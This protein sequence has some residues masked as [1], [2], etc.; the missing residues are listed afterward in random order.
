MP[1]QL[2]GAVGRLQ[3][4]L[5]ARAAR[6]PVGQL[7]EQPAR[8][9]GDVGDGRVEIV[10]H[11]R[12][13]LTDFSAGRGARGRRCA[14]APRRGLELAGLLE[15]LLQPRQRAGVS[16]RV[17]QFVLRVGDVVN[18]LM[19]PGGVLIPTEGGRQSIQAGFGQLEAQVIKVGMAAEQPVPPSR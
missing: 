9:L 15:Q 6:R 19:R 11:G 8:V 16:G 17:E 10:G 12:G 4:L 2:S 7:A 5:G 3:R 1:H 13:Q 18:P 14:A